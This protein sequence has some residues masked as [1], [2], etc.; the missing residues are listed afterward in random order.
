MRQAGTLG[1]CKRNQLGPVFSGRERIHCVPIAFTGGVQST[2]EVW[3][4]MPSEENSVFMTRIVHA[5]VYL[6]IIWEGKE[7]EFPFSRNNTSFGLAFCMPLGVKYRLQGHMMTFSS[8]TNLHG[9]WPI[10]NGKNFTM[11]NIFQIGSL[12]ID[13]VEDNWPTKHGY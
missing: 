10:P 8:L 4:K 6:L 13:W 9:M 5:H 12:F 3:L 1:L 7:V 2:T 11:I